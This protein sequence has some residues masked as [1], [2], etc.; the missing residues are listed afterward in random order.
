[1]VS[2]KC[3]YAQGAHPRILEAITRT[4]AEHTEV[5]GED[6]HSSAAAKLIT[7]QTKRECF[8]SFV[9]GGTIA[10]LVVI[11]H[12][13]RPHQAVIAADTGHIFTNE[14]GAI[15]STGHKIVTH[16]GEDGKL[17][18]EMICKV[19]GKHGHV[20]FT[21]Q[22]RLVYISQPTE[23]GTV[24]SKAEL[25]AL[26]ATCQERGL[27]LFVDG[28]RLGCA[29]AL[30]D[31]TIADL[32]MLTDAFTIGGTKNGGL[33][34][35][36]V[37]IPNAKISEDFLFSVRQKGA[38]LAPGRLLG[39]QFEE[40][41]R[42]GLYLELGRWANEMSAL[43]K[44]GLKSLG[45]RFYAESPTNQQF[46][47][48]RN[49]VIEKLEKEYMILALETVEEESVV[50]LVTSHATTRKQVEGFIKLVEEAIR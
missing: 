23:L 41:F 13:L 26:Y 45:I 6:E 17:T 34:G 47:W 3:D 19:L 2:F 50:R 10:N 49:E 1:M 36:A 22:P 16:P 4:N 8:V 37:V 29:L 32:A 38:L 42:D 15:E 11:S 20:P 14:T 44:S 24:Y 35:E 28:A 12:F 33:F 30:G 7:K 9:P 48:L 18:P 31:A 43:L 39:V 40:L 46:V 25:T 21:V 5:Y 27:Y